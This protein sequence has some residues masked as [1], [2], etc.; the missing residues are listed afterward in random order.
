MCPGVALC[1]IPS[2]G[3]A[4]PPKAKQLGPVPVAQELFLEGMD[5][6]VAGRT[7]EGRE[8]LQKSLDI[9][10][11]QRVLAYLI[12]L[13]CRLKQ[14]ER[15]RSLLAWLNTR[16]ISPAIFH[17]LAA[18]FQSGGGC[19][20]EV[21][22]GNAIA[23]LYKCDARVRVESDPPG[24][25]VQSLQRGEGMGYLEWG[26]TPV[27]RVGLCP[28]DLQI[29]LRKWGYQESYRS[30]RLAPHANEVQIFHLVQHDR[31]TFLD[32]YRRTAALGVSS[33]WMLG[34]TDGVWR[35]E[36]A[37]TVGPAISTWMREFRL[38]GEL[39][40]RHTPAGSRDG[41]VARVY[42]EYAFPLMRS[43]PLPTLDTRPINLFAGLGGEA[44]G[45]SPRSMGGSIHAGVHLYWLTVGGYYTAGLGLWD[46]RLYHWSAGVMTSV[47]IYL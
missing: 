2:P 21:G 36:P 13:D 29:E 38:T 47:F 18:Q 15:A 27:E 45:W 8:H 42:A 32:S 11:S 9:L 34:G 22:N 43:D 14:C 44:S 37:F 39:H 41:A 28:G 31:D 12:I 7:A 35:S 20:G 23:N 46:G 30:I 5:L 25:T 10:F 1:Q 19:P 40:Y 6:V 33:R 24:A 4:P 17:E 3:A 16:E 26:A